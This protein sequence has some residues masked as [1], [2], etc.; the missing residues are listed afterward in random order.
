[1]ISA[2]TRLLV[3][4][5]AI[6]LLAGCPAYNTFNSTRTAAPGKPEFLIAAG[7][8]GA[9]GAQLAATG[10]G[11]ATGRNYQLTG[12][13]RFGI[14]PGLDL[15][16]RLRL[17]DLTVGGDIKLRFL[18]TEKLQIAVA[19]MFQTSLG[20]P[21]LNAALQLL[22]D[23][24]AAFSA[25]DFTVPLLFGIPFE[26][27]H[28][29]VVGAKLTLSNWNARVIAEGPFQGSSVG[30]SHI[31]PGVMIGVDWWINENLRAMPEFNF[32]MGFDGTF[33]FALGVAAVFSP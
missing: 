33:F 30:Q 10:V 28:L 32:H 1:L 11:I 19:P 14:A 6:T 15:G 22:E 31:Q 27:N 2:S 24:I 20:W 21:I 29:F 3:A 16:V 13:A 26:E 23:D 9:G 8:T 17:N 7:H 5:V 12:M 4:V 18:N 25:Y